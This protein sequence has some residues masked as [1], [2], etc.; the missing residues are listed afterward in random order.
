MDKQ[1]ILELEQGAISFAEVTCKL[2][3]QPTMPL[4]DGDWQVMN[5]N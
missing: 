3:N 4:K 2:S 1:E 5:R